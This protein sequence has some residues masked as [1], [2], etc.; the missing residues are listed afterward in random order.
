MDYFNLFIIGALCV[1]LT[2]IIAFIVHCA[3][4]IVFKWPSKEDLPILQVLKQSKLVFFIWLILSP[5]V[6][7]IFVKM[8]SAMLDFSHYYEP[9]GYFYGFIIYG[10]L[11]FSLFIHLLYC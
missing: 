3:V 1:C 2:S 8:G 4:S 7:M 6:Y 5:I 9:I 11:F 10:C